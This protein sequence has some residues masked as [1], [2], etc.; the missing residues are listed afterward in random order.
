[1]TCCL[2]E[3][4]QEGQHQSEQANSLGQG[5]AQNGVVEQ[6]LNL[7]GLAGAGDQ[8]VSEDG[9]DTQTDTGQGNSGQTSTDEVQTLDLD[10]D[11]GGG[12]LG[13]NGQGGSRALGGLDG[14]TAHHI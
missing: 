2:R 11:S 9:T 13:D 5:E 3:Q 8:Q 7:V 4:H 14:Q 10:G 1:M 12:A 6:H